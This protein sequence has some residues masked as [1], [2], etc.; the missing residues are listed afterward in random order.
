MIRALRVEA[1]YIDTRVK[2]LAVSAK[3]AA[4]ARP[5]GNL[6]HLGPITC[7]AV[8]NRGPLFFSGGSDGKIKMWN[9]ATREL[10]GSLSGHREPVNS[11]INFFK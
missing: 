7:L 9:Y 4:K 10:V 5:I 8:A 11:Y 2:P 1:Q 3:A 6:A